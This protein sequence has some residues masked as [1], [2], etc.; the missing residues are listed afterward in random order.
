LNGK[1][2]KWQTIMITHVHSVTQHM[3]NFLFL[4]FLLRNIF[5]RSENFA[6][7]L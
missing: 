4:Y 7:F 1:N 2:N 6:C 3:V 5:D